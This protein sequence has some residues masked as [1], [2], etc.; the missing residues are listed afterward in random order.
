[1]I[2]LVRFLKFL[3]SF[4]LAALVAGLGVAAAYAGKWARELPDYRQLD[5]LTRSLGAETKVYARDNTPLGS[6]IP[7]IGEQA[8]SRTLVTLDEISPFMISALISNED[9]RFF[10]HYGLDPYGLLRQFRRLSQGENVQGGSTLTNQLVKNTLLLEE[11]NQARTPDRKLKEWMLSVQIERSFTKEEILQ[12]YLNT[13]YW[14]DGGP[15]ELYGIY[16]ASQAYFR[17]T[18]KALTLAQSAYLTALVPRAGRYFDYKAVRPIMKILL[19]RMVEDKWITQAQADAA[20]QEKLQ[21]RGW[22]VTYDAA[23]NISSAKLVD[24][25]AKELKAVTSTRAPHFV[26]QV[27][28]ELVRT[29]GQDVVYGSGGL[30]VYTTL[31]PKIQT[32][33]ETA[34]REASGLPPGATLAATIMDPYTA[35]VLGM[36]GQK[37]NGTQPPDDWNNAAQGQRQIGSTIKPL[38]YTTALSTGLRQDHREEDRPVSFPCPVGCKDGVYEPQNFEGATTYRNMTIREALDRSL[39]L[40]TV[41]LADRIGLETLFAKIR[42]LGIPPNDGTGLAAAL[43]AVETTPIKMAAAY[44]PFVNGGG[45][46]APRYITRVTNARGAV[47]YDAANDP[48][49]P[50]RVWTPQIAYLGLNLIEGVVNDLTPAQGGLA[51]KAKFGDWPVAGKT[52]TSNGPKD[53]WFVGTTP[54]YTGAVWVGKQKGGDMPVNYYSGEVNAPIWRRMMELAHAG[55]S[56]TQFTP[57][58]GIV[59]DEAPDPGYLPG[60]KMAFLDPRYRDAANTTTEAQAPPPTV[61]RETSYA[62]VS[63][64]PRTVIISLDRSTNR[65]ATEFTPPQNVVQRRIYVEELPAYAPDDSPKPLADEKPDPDAL[66]AARNE[67]GAPE[68]KTEPLGK[69]PTGTPAPKSP[70]TTP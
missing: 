31:D 69:P 33:V 12:N 43:G 34:S 58:P 8:I 9:R 49:R 11:Y 28:Q 57:P 54:L 45:Y 35:E 29:F 65:L 63:S 41:R 52:G 55:R 44:A 30:R 70:P 14:G 4:L 25:S 10:E 66:K 60:V 5:N 19:A 22:Q 18:P 21:P 50:V 20:W 15:V 38:L 67:G 61:Y 59:F 46:R 62:R 27:E 7:K 3:T 53:F 56:V 40:V 47:L 13:I 68:A 16:S 23:G 39:N 51:T 1:M 42:Q 48:L 36:V 37:L 24:P 32:A 17:T 2:F 6:L 26:R 64:D